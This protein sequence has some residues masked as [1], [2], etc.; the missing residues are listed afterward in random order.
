MNRSVN[1]NIY[2]FPQFLI[3]ALA[4]QSLLPPGM[5]MGRVLGR[6]LPGLPRRQA[7]SVHFPSS[8]SCSFPFPWAAFFLLLMLLQEGWEKCSRRKCGR[9]KGC[10]TLRRSTS[11]SPRPHQHR[12]GKAISRM[13]YLWTS[14]IFISHF[15][16]WPT[17]QHTGRP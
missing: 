8:T 14:F 15:H 16:N 2:H 6:P 1:I 5:G 9:A 11:S 7:R 10:F 13:Q 4:G 17:R 3:V 12:A